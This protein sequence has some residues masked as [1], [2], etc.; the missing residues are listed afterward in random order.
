[1][2]SV[3]WSP[4]TVHTLVLLDAALPELPLLLGGLEAGCQALPVSPDQ[5]ALTLLAAAVRT[6][7]QQGQLSPHWRLAVVAHGSPGQV[8][9]GSEP[10]NATSVQARS[11]AWR[12]LAPTA[13][14][15]FS[16]FAGVDGSLASALTAVCAAPVHASRGVVGHS[17]VGGSWVLEAQSAPAAANAVVPFNRAVVA[18]WGFGLAVF[19][20]S[21]GGSGDGGTIVTPSNS[22][23][24]VR[25]NLISGNTV[26][27]VS[28]SGQLVVPLQSGDNISGGEINLDSGTSYSLAL[29]SGASVTMTA[30]QHNGASSI[31]GSGSGSGS[32]TITL[33]TAGTVTG[34]A[35]IEA[36][37]LAAGS[38]QFNVGAANQHVNALAMTTGDVLTLTGSDA[39]TLTSTN[40]AINASA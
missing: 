37:V 9:I 22:T 30:A 7:S 5:D 29:N 3:A 11:A 4:A 23:E 28:G 33:T 24:D 12:A 15:L 20:Y 27:V 10:L 35:A 21:T 36:Y 19:Y 13:I 1:V 8:A 14:D 38:Q 26:Y 39:L 17:S 31:S 32:E 34:A 40:A 6:A 2:K 25:A 18:G 16:C